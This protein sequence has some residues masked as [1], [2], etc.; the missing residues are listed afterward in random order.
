[1]KKILSFLIF[2]FLIFLIPYQ[3]QAIVLVDTGAPPVSSGGD[4]LSQA[5]WLAGQFNVADFYSI[6]DIQGWMG[7]RSSGLV[8]VV[9]YNGSVP[10]AFPDTKLIP[11]TGNESFR[12]SV[13]LAGNNNLNDWHGISGLNWNL[14][15][16]D[17]WV[18]FENKGISNF[19]GWMP[20]PAP[21]P[22]THYAYYATANGKYIGVDSAIPLGFRI[23]ANAV[24]EPASL[25][26]FS[27]GVVGMLLKKRKKMTKNWL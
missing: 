7:I 15:P 21:Q 11:N 26:L 8:D 19:E 24:P 22:L 4:T 13:F 2:A 16:G 1:M 10:G 18:A 20:S 5:Q 23:N 14:S 17:Y 12:Q 25:L 9:I 6:T 27:G 3:A